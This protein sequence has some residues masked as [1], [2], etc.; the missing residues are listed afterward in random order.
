MKVSKLIVGID[1]I[2][3]SDLNG[4]RRAGVEFVRLPENL[5][6]NP[7]KVKPYASLSIS[8]KEVD[9]NTIYTATLK[10]KT[11]GVILEKHFC[12]RATLLDGSSLLLG[13]NSRPYPQATAVE[14]MPE[15]VTDN[16][17][18]EYQITY[19]T[20]LRIPKIIE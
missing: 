13:A 11:C 12:Y 9:K 4:M 16:Q 6:W 15:A 20:S 14:S 18:T 2:K 5:V 19:S 7:I 8:D 17:L 10:F 3:S 1:W